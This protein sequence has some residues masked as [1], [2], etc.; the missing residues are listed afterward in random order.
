M[1]CGAGDVLERDL[2]ADLSDGMRWHSRCIIQ[3][4]P[5]C[6]V[7]AAARSSS[8]PSMVEEGFE[9]T[10]PVSFFQLVMVSCCL[11]FKRSEHGRVLDGSLYETLRRV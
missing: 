2:A 4:S 1:R 7:K 9:P 11:S 5:L 8:N 3:G 6:S 10:F